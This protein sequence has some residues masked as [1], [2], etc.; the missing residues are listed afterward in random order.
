MNFKRSGCVVKREFVPCRC[1]VTDRAVPSK[2]DWVNLWE[3]CYYGDRIHRGAGTFSFSPSPFATFPSPQRKRWEQE[4]NSRKSKWYPDCSRSRSHS[5]TAPR[6]SV[7]NRLYSCTLFI[8]EVF[9]VE[10]KK[11]CFLKTMVKINEP[12]TSFFYAIEDICPFFNL[13]SEFYNVYTRTGVR[14]RNRPT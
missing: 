10:Q 11:C 1:D 8:F 14:C 9:R 12:H 3:T 13:H 2:G 6:L 5:E 4:N 7:H